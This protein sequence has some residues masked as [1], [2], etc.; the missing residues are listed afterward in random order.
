M[1][2][3]I[4]IGALVAGVAL[5]AAI[6]LVAY[7]VYPNIHGAKVVGSNVASMVVMR[8]VAIGL[9]RYRQEHG[10]YPSA[11]SI[12]DLQKKADPFLAGARLTD[13]WGEPLVVDVTPASYTL[14][15]KG[16]KRTGGHQF[17]GAVTFG[18]HSITLK[19]GVF[20]QYDARAATTAAD[21]EGQMAAERSR[22]RAGV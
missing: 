12:A 6:V 18:G 5:I 19:D 3:G 9:E 2:R 13:K 14:T 4:V 10:S 8:D 1:K 20:V 16:A 7:F 22:P 15:S 11:Q 17:G 21:F